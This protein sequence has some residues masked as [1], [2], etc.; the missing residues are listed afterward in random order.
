MTTVSLP[1]EGYSPFIDFLKGMAILCVLWTHVYIAQPQTLFVLWGGMAV[2][3]FILIQV[4]HAFRKG[5][6]KV[7]FPKL[8]KVLGRIMAPAFIVWMLLFAINLVF[9]GSVLYADQ[10][11]ENWGFGPGCY[12]P[13]LYLEFALLLPLVAWVLKRL[14]RPLYIFLFCLVVSILLEVFCA[15]VHPAPWLYSKLFFRYFFLIYLGY[16]WIENGITPSVKTVLLALVSAASILVFQYLDP[17]LE[18]FFYHTAW[19]VHHWICYFWLLYVLVYL[20]GLVHR[21]DWFSGK[22]N[23]LLEYFGRASWDIFVC[24]MFFFALIHPDKLTW[25]GN[26]W[27]RLIVFV[28]STLTLSLGLGCLVYHLRTANKNS[29]KNDKIVDKEDPAT[30]HQETV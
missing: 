10:A 26:T 2:P 29:R 9:P 11:L 30:G 27:V 5:L 13:W 21:A 15:L 4:V 6:E 17:D 24:Q 20:L 25:I 14:G 18:P 16:E 3:T 8:G 22:F 19:R 23:R 1:K 28:V 7:R 12:Y